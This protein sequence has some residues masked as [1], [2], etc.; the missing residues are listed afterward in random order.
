[1]KYAVKPTL[2]CVELLSSVSAVQTWA[3]RVRVAAGV[4]IFFTCWLTPKDATYVQLVFHGG[5]LT[6]VVGADTSLLNFAPGT[7][8]SSG[9]VEGFLQGQNFIAARLLD[10]DGN[11]IYPFTD[12][13]AKLRAAGFETISCRTSQR[14]GP[15]EVIDFCLL[16]SA[17]GASTQAH[18]TYAF[19]GITITAADADLANTLAALDNNP[20]PIVTYKFTNTLAVLVEEEKVTEAAPEASITFGFYGKLPQPH[21]TYI[22]LA[23][24]AGLQVSDAPTHV[25]VPNPENVPAKFRGIAQGPTLISS[26]QF[27]KIIEDAKK[28]EN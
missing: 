18:G 19:D 22:E 25:V 20:S 24:D 10:H 17:D 13:C 9:I 3:E 4:P 8:I 2:R 1:M 7:G 21:K 14:R 16:Y 6:S 27:T 15:K 23:Q 26:D 11:S 5:K 12:A 28:K